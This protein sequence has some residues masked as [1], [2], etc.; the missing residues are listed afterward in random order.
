MA[1]GAAIRHAA[2][3]KLK[4]HSRRSTNPSSNPWRLRSLV[5]TKTTLLRVQCDS[6]APLAVRTEILSAFGSLP[7]RRFAKRPMS[8]IGSCWCLEFPSRKLFR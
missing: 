5:D 3:A 8:A 2:L 4:S 6:C 1:A 7:F